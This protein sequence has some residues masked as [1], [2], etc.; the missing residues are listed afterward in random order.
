MTNVSTSLM[1][2]VIEVDSNSQ[3]F[4]SCKN[5]NKEKQFFGGLRCCF[6]AVVPKVRGG[7][8]FLARRANE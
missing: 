2:K 6:R 7:G 5:L 8:G 3:F 4:R 1:S